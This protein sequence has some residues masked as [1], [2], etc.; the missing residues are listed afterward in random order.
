MSRASPEA[1]VVA[2]GEAL[3]EIVRD[4][5]AWR[6]RY[7]GDTLNTA[8]YLSR[9]GIRTAY[10]TAIGRDP[11]SEEMRE[12]WRAEGLDV[13]WVLTDGSRIP[14]LYAIRT[15]TEGE[16]RFYYWLRQSAARRRLSLS[17]IDAAMT[18]ARSTPL[19]Y[20]SGITLSLYSLAACRR[21]CAL[22]LAVRSAGGRVP[23]IRIIARAFGGMRLLRAGAGR[24]ALASL[25]CLRERGQIRRRRLPRRRDGVKSESRRATWPR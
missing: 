6:L 8:I 25:R 12:T 9:L 3:L 14:G 4:G 20:L 11:F 10:L 18:A 5:D 16:R 2:V 15:D 7:G 13:S 1:P 17:G 19:L 22:A 24:P 21:L 23:S